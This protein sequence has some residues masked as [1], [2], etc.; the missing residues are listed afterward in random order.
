LSRW[1]PGRYIT[2]T[3]PARHFCGYLAVEYQTEDGKCGTMNV[4]ADVNPFARRPAFEAQG[5]P[6]Q[7]GL[8]VVH[9][10]ACECRLCY[11]PDLAEL[12]AQAK[13]RTPWPKT[14]SMSRADFAYLA[15]ILSALDF[16]ADEG[17]PNGAGGTVKRYV[18]EHVAYHLADT[19]PRFDRERFL[20]AATG[21]L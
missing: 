4:R 6:Y 14:P 21:A 9:P 12:E 13:A 17:M 2:V 1:A 5:A 19:N 7:S 16:L 15:R 3:A 20:A 18:A 10:P 8:V 11:A